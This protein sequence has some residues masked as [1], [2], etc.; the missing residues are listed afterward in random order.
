MEHVAAGELSKIFSRWS[1][2][3]G[4]LVSQWTRKG[5][6]GRAFNFDNTLGSAAKGVISLVVLQG[7][8]PVENTRTKDRMIHTG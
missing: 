6:L 8:G 1:A 2:K 3:T 7:K 5:G 4:V